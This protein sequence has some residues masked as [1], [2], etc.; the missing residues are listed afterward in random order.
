MESLI[1]RIQSLERVIISSSQQQATEHEKPQEDRNASIPHLTCDEVPFLPL[2]SEQGVYSPPKHPEHATMTYHVPLDTLVNPKSAG[3]NIETTGEAV[4][5]GGS[6]ATHFMQQ[7]KETIPGTGQ[8]LS[9]GVRSSSGPPSSKGTQLST[10]K[11]R[12]SV[13]SSGNLSL[14]PRGLADTLLENYWTKAYTLYPFVYKPSFAHAYEDLWKPFHELQSDEKSHDLGL[15]TPG[16]SDSRT[17]VFHCAL[18]AIFALSCQ[19]S[20]PGMLPQER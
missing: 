5:D 6:S 19:L 18:N 13:S 15:G 12:G 8:M 10:S 16:V 2:A 20:C 14:P 9:H 7:V 11:S 17:I 4:L 1:D 3:R